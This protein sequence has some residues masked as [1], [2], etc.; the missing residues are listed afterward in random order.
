MNNV[1]KVYHAY[2]IKWQY[3]Y[4]VTILSIRL[5]YSELQKKNNNFFYLI[6]TVKK[7]RPIPISLI[8]YCQYASF[9]AKDKE[10]GF[11]TDR[12]VE[13]LVGEAG[14]GKKIL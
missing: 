13:V 11:Y 1:M 10:K 2:Q 14:I 5:F 8:H 6:Y 9:S 7:S 12:W 3:K 4:F